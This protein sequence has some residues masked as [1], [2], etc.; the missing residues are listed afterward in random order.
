MCIGIKLHVSL[1]CTHIHLYI[2]VPLGVLPKNEVKYE[3]MIDIL[4]HL[5]C[6]V[7]SKQIQREVTVPGTD[8]KLTLDDHEFSTTLVGGDQVTVA[9]IRGAQRIRSNSENKL[10]GLAAV[11]P[12]VE[13][14]HSKQCLLQVNGIHYVSMDHACF[15]PYMHGSPHYR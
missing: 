4:Q 14:W 7:P 12:V 13:D 15:K 3:D 6:Y 11:L 5:H 2:Q 9:R 10:N 1:I 8:E